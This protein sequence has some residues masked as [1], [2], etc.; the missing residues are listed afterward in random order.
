MFVF[1][2]AGGPRVR[3]GLTIEGQMYLIVRLSW[4]FSEKMG[5]NLF[6]KESLV[7]LRESRGG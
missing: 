1:L 4:P 3:L 7:D 6:L 5:F 2:I